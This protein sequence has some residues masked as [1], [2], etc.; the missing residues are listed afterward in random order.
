M[1]HG[2]LR[3]QLVYNEELLEVYKVYMLHLVAK[4][5]LYSIPFFEIPGKLIASTQKILLFNDFYEEIGGE[6]CFEDQFPPCIFTE[7]DHG[8]LVFISIGWFS[9]ER[10]QETPTSHMIFMGKSGWFPVKMFP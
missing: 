5:M 9:R 1:F 8:H 10:N 4:M 7:R 6:Q 3:K 2:A